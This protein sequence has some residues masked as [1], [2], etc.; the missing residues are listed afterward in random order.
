MSAV[1]C[2]GG[3]EGLQVPQAEPAAQVQAGICTEVRASERV[4]GIADKS[5]LLIGF[6]KRSSGEG[7]ADAGWIQG[8]ALL[9][10]KAARLK[11]ESPATTSSAAEWNKTLEIHDKNVSF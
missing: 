8:F 1:W 10:S 7:S 6:A 11:Q 9:S 2:D 3:E 5:G 4:G